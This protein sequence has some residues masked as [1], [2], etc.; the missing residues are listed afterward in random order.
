M[1][2]LEELYHLLGYLE[3]LSMKVL[4]LPQEMEKVKLIIQTNSFFEGTIGHIY[5]TDSDDKDEWDS[6]WQDEYVDCTYQRNWSEEDYEEAGWDIDDIDP[7]HDPSQ[8]P[9]IDVFGPGEDAE[10]AYLNHD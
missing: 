7:S 5:T 10:M 3:G 9:W 8:N 2:D 6:D 1:T 4:V